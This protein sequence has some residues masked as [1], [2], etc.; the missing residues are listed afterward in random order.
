MAPWLLAC[1]CSVAAGVAEMAGFS[2]TPNMKGFGA[3]GAAT[4]VVGRPKLKGLVGASAGVP[5]LG[6]SLAGA[7]NWNSLAGSVVGGAPCL[8]VCCSSEEPNFRGFACSAVLEPNLKAGSGGAEPNVN[9]FAG[10]FAAGPKLNPLLGSDAVGASL[11]LLPAPSAAE[12][13]RPGWKGFACSPPPA[14]PKT[15]SP[16]VDPD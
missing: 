16:G 10:S 7:P 13:E 5:N 1:N 11:T 4:V 12:V 9:G 6:A 8:W 14:E 2:V 15:T 3:A